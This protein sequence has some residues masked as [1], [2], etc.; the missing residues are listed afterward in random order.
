[1]TRGVIK[2]RAGGSGKRRGPR[3][4]SERL[5]KVP[6]LKVI[7]GVALSLICVGVVLLASVALLQSMQIPGFITFG[8]LTPITLLGFLWG[9][10]DRMFYVMLGATAALWIVGTILLI[11]SSHAFARLAGVS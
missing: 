2:Y 4:P 9:R 10:R 8:V 3:P 5:E 1:M 6:I 7:Y 11:L